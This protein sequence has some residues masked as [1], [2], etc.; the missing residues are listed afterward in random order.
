MGRKRKSNWADDDGSSSDEGSSGDDDRGLN[1]DEREERVLFRGKRGKRKARTE[2]DKML[3]VFAEDS[4]EVD[5]RRGGGRYAKSGRRAGGMYDAGVAFVKGVRN[6]GG[7]GDGVG[8][9]EEQEERGEGDG[10]GDKQEDD[11]MEVEGE[12]GEDGDGAGQPRDKTEDEEMSDAEGHGGLGLGMGM[13]TGLGLGMGRGGLGLGTGLPSQFG[14]AGGDS[15]R[16][17]N[18]HMSHLRKTVSLSPSPTP[19]RPST[20][21]NPTPR[22]QKADRDFG[23]WE[24]TSSGIGSKLLRAMGWKPG[25]GLGKDRA[26]MV[27]P[28]DVKLRPQRAGLGTI[29]ERTEAVRE[30]QRV[31]KETHGI[32]YGEESEESDNNGGGKRKS[33]KRKDSDEAQVRPKSSQWKKSRPPKSAKPSYITPADLLAADTSALPD[34]AASP[35]VQ[36][37]TIIDLTGPSARVRDI[38]SLSTVTP[39]HPSLIDP[40]KHLPELRHN[41]RL[42]ADLARSDLVSAGRALR[43]EDAQRARWERERSAAQTAKAQAAAAEVAVAEL[44]KAAEQL[45]IASRAAAADGAGDGVVVRGRAGRSDDP[46][47]LGLSRPSGKSARAS[48]AV[49]PSDP[50]DVD[51]ESLEESSLSLLTPHFV[52]LASLPQTTPLPASLGLPTPSTLAVS[53]AQPVLARLW[54]TWDPLSN[55]APGLAWLSRWGTLM[56]PPPA[57]PP[58]SAG[59]R[60][61]PSIELKSNCMS[62]YEALLWSSWLPPL[63]SAASRWDPGAPESMLKVVEAW[64]GDGKQGG[65]IGKDTDPVLPAWLHHHVLDQLVL[66]KLVRFVALWRPSA[67]SDPTNTPPAHLWALPW[68]AV[69]NPPGWGEGHWTDPLVDAARRRLEGELRGR[70]NPKDTWGVEEV[71][72]WM[73]VFAPAALSTMLRRCVLPKLILSLR[74]QLVVNPA[75][76][77]LKPLHWLLAWYSAGLLPPH[78]T[79]ALIAVELRPKWMRALWTW[80]AHSGADLGEVARWYAAWR[81]EV[82]PEVAKEEPLEK[83]WREALDAMNDAVAKRKNGDSV[84]IPRE[85]VG[86]ADAGDA[87]PLPDFLAYDLVAGNAQRSSRQPSA[88]AKATPGPASLTYRDHLEAFFA[89]HDLVMEPAQAASVEH[90]RVVYRVGPPGGSGRGRSRGKGVF[91]S[92]DEGVVYV[93]E[94]GSWLPAAEEEVVA[95]ANG[96]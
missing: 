23:K 66:P 15:G 16:N 65:A 25:Q 51:D 43:A 29:D 2:E 44:A 50:I 76:P 91:V 39:S 8:Q 67:T 75:S 6:G 64:C 93:R 96:V 17:S 45:S 36:P 33:R 22:P 55:P 40:T 78:L 74:T 80:L 62:P 31:M 13:E 38:S 88:P 86:E 68:L 52:N 37:S 47:D 59:S 10:D 20:P 89:S 1:A 84:T 83:L 56:N 26:G 73:E 28:I 19:S 48:K 21:S 30:Q 32:D 9:E 24:S 63:R 34:G 61:A 41:L 71:G 7:E 11:E 70:W 54:R 42:L 69:P 4:D 18:P 81:G 60:Y 82:P 94:S 90:G 35:S 12:E 14:G 57:P 79:S 92:M 5:G 77:D 49:Q 27:K 53:A 46:M 72:R 87:P 58:R 3:G 95:K 85:F